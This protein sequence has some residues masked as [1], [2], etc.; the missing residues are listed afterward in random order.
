[1]A[2]HFSLAQLSAVE[3]VKWPAAHGYV[4]GSGKRERKKR[5]ESN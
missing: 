5:V 3:E 1:M 4:V 2:P